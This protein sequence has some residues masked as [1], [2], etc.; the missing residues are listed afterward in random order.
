MF[1]VAFVLYRIAFAVSLATG[2][3]KAARVSGSPIPVAL[4][5]YSGSVLF[6]GQLVSHGDI[7]AYGW[8]FVGL[9]IA[10][11]SASLKKKVSATPTV[12]S[13]RVAHK[14][15]AIPEVFPARS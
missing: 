9:T 8:I 5:G 7:Q 12:R 6:N 3:F 13:V 4:F 2:A 14:L 1:G 11:S 15:P 10:V